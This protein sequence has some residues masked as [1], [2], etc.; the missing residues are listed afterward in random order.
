MQR[1][2]ILVIAPS[3]SG[4]TRLVSETIRKL[5]RIAVFDQ[6]ADTQYIPTNDPNVIVVT[7]RPKEFATAIGSFLPKEEQ[8][9]QRFRVVYHPVTTEVQDNGLMESPEFGM[10]VKVCQER[11]HMYLVIDEAHL[12]CNSY[13][14]PKE[15][16]LANL[17][18]RHDELSLILIAQRINGI[19]PAIREN[20][21]EFYFWK[22]ITPTGL[23]MVGEYCGTEVAEQV[24][25]LRAVELDADDNFVA[26]G[27][28]LH[29]SKFRGVEEVTE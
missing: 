11:G 14:C 28:Y 29:W 4:K 16:M 21:D 18:G 1:R 26:P 15:L 5:D 27:Q 13:N 12:W 3:G 2:I 6:V 9:K 22:I 19:H 20:A 24:K 7:G 23:K 17:V 10:I 25:N 8:E